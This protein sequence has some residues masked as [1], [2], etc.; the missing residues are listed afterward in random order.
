MTF[1]LPP[2]GNGQRSWQC[3]DCERPDPLSSKTINGWIKGLV[4]REPLDQ[5]T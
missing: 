5:P 4:L 2:G 1:A 3:F